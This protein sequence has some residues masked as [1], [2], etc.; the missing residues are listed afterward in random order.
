MDVLREGGQ[1]VKRRADGQGG[2]LVE[3]VQDGLIVVAALVLVQIR[4]QLR[5][6]DGAAGA[7]D[8]RVLL[9]VLA[10]ADA[11]VLGAVL[12][13]GEDA[14]EGDARVG[15]VERFQRRIGTGIA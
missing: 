6:L 10:E 8:G 14:V 5:P 9:E 1:E 11:A 3:T 13:Q 7:D 2:V 4:A 12:A 15:L